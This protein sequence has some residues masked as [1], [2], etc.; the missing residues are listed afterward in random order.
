MS[1][2]FEWQLRKK[3]LI[4]NCHRIKLL[5]SGQKKDFKESQM[6]HMLFPTQRVDSR[7]SNKR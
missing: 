7:G 5:S 3:M 2:P 1:I 6:S 4:I